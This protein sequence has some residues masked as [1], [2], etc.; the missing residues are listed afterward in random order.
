M[1]TGNNA[2]FVPIPTVM[3]DYGNAPFLWLVDGPGRGGVSTNLC[4][5]VC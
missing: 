4:D 2:S 5:G 1:K 3:V